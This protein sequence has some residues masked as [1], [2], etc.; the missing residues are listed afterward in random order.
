[1]NNIDE[2]ITCENVTKLSKED[3]ESCKITFDNE[4]NAKVNIIGKGKFKDLAICNGTKTSVE[5]SDTCSTDAKYF[6]YED[7]EGGISITGYSIEGGLDVVIPSSIN[8]KQVVSIGNTAFCF[9]KLTSVTIPSSVTSIGK[10]AFA[11]N[12]LTSVT[13]PNSVTSIGSSAFLKNVSS[14]PNLTKIINKTGKS[15]DWGYIV[16]N[17]SGYDFVTGTVVNS[18]GNVEVVSE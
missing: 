3:Y 7:V 5:L 14:N 9:N 2:V 11:Y 10:G 4:G 15:F 17:S 1:M 13:I 6:A 18:S 16:N 8:G 12:K